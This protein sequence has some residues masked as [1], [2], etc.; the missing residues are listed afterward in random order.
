MKLVLAALTI[1]LLIITTNQDNKIKYLEKEI[2]YI[3]LDLIV[4][5]SIMHYHMGECLGE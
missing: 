4:A 3:N 1:T 2:Y 5:D